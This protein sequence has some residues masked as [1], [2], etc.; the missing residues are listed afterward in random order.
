METNWDR[1]FLDL[2]FFVARWS[3]DPSTKVGCVIVKDKYVLSMGYN[4]FPKGVSDD[5]Y[6]LED[7]ERKNLRMVHAEANAILTAGRNGA[8]CQ[9]STL[10]TSLNPCSSCATLIAQS[11]ITRVVT[12]DTPVFPERW[13]TSFYEGKL[14]LEESGIAYD[15]I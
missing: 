14:I 11:G 4:G 5:L 3:K 1:R 6:V 7:R 13:K 9:G 8:S 15:C 12:L 2:A 10:Y